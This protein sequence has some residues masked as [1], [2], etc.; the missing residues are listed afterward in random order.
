MALDPKITK[1]A[2]GVATLSWT[3]DPKAIAYDIIT[4]SGQ[5]VQAGKNATTAKLGTNLPEPINASISP[6]Y[7]QAYE[8]AVYPPV[9]PLTITQTIKDGDTL[10]APLVWEANPSKDGRVDFFI[11]GALKWTENIRPYQFNGDGGKLDPATLSNGPHEFKTVVTL[12]G[13]TATAKANAAVNVVVPP[14]PTGA[15]RPLL[16]P[17][18]DSTG[19]DDAILNEGLTNATTRKWL[20]DHWYKPVLYLSRWPYLTPQ[21]VRYIDAF[22]IYT[23]QANIDFSLVLKDPA[24]GKPLYIDWGCSGGKCPQWAGDIGNPAFKKTIIDKCKQAVADG[25]QGIF[26]D[27]VNLVPNLTTGAVKVSVPAGYTATTFKAAF[28]TFME[29]IRAAVPSAFLLHN[30]VWSHSP[31]HD[32]DDPNVIRQIKASNMCNLERGINDGGLTAGTGEWSINRYFKYVDKVHSLGRNI[33][34]MGYATDKP[35]A[36]ANLCAAWMTFE[37]GDVHQSKL[38]YPDVWPVEYDWDL[39]DPKGAR[40]YVNGVYRREFTKGYVTL[41][42]PPA[43]IGTIVKTA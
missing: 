15:K 7:P 1:D 18:T 30:S 23:S 28:A 10:S 31:N 5:H 3:A 16:A 14:P 12:G 22:A 25:F 4:P 24:S 19:R 13:Q 36:I 38:R 37:P 8:A 34:Y 6:A 32:G 9:V 33:S 2:A 11:D 20:Q 42:D 29:E 17:L 35:G 27:D 21:A 41:S 26:L 40:T 39:G 43:K